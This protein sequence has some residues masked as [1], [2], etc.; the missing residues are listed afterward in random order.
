MRLDLEDPRFWDGAF[1]KWKKNPHN[2]P[3]PGKHPWPN[4]PWNLYKEMYDITMH[5]EY[6]DM[7]EQKL[8][9]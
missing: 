6:K 7:Y 4:H 9:E 8:V 1:E 5:F 3:M 2:Q